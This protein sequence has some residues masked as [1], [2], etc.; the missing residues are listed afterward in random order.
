[1]LRRQQSCELL[2]TAAVQRGPGQREVCKQRE[3]G[4]SSHRLAIGT[5]KELPLTEVVVPLKPNS[6]ANTL[7]DVT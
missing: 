3:T 7:L 2:E 4:S 1:M 6:T 5:F